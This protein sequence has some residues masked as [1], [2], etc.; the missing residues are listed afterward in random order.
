MM[1]IRFPLTTTALALVLNIYSV[2]DGFCMDDGQQKKHVRTSRS[3]TPEIKNVRRAPLPPESAGGGESNMSRNS[4]VPSDQFDELYARALQYK[5]DIKAL[6]REIKA[7]K[8]ALTNQSSLPL[9]TMVELESM[10]RLSLYKERSEEWASLQQQSISDRE[11]RESIASLQEEKK[12]FVLRLAEAQR[13]LDEGSGKI[14]LLT[15]QL[16]EE[17]LGRATK[18]QELIDQLSV[19]QQQL[20]EKGKNSSSATPQGLIA[21]YKEQ[22]SILPPVDQEI[23]LKAL[24]QQD[25]R[26]KDCSIM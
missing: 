14:Q 7:A 6:K 22:F 21:K 15:N 4:V 2:T 12:K 17:K 25:K 26:K 18:T 23:V 20:D 8:E 10:R 3:S 11:D 5:A 9:Q 24:L 1:M 13:L 19:V 16:A